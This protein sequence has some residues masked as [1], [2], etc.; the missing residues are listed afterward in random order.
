MARVLRLSAL[1]IILLNGA[2]ALVVLLRPAL[3]RDPSARVA[4]LVLMTI[5]S[6][7]M[8]WVARATL[9]MTSLRSA[10]AQ[11][12]PFELAQAKLVAMPLF[13]P[14]V[15]WGMLADG[16]ASKTGIILLCLFS[17]MAG[18]TLIT[19][20]RFA[21]V[22]GR[23]FFQPAF[24]LFACELARSE[25]TSFEVS[26]SAL[27]GLTDRDVS[28]RVVLRTTTGD[29]FVL[30]LVGSHARAALSFE[31]SAPRLPVAPAPKPAAQIPLDHPEMA[32]LLV[33]GTPL[34]LGA[35]AVANVAAFVFFSRT[36]RAERQVRISL[37]EARY[38][39][40][41]FAYQD[42]M[43]ALLRTY[44]PDRRFSKA[45]L[46]IIAVLTLMIGSAL[47]AVAFA[48]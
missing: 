8:L 22:E 20:A 1:L 28:Q 38:W 36:R 17:A 46:I 30:H 43:P 10:G 26:P 12:A 41:M 48:A 23:L 24:S 21:A 11:L 3:Q 16:Q 9:S 15:V 35:V 44:G 5:C 39:V 29:E 18:A 31:P 47:I 4:A 2:F 40:L 33:A 19:H 27:H 32:R 13:A 34:V 45:M 14:L 7:L 25:L 42:R 37:G 6:A